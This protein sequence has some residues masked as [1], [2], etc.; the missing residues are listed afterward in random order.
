MSSSVYLLPMSTRSSGW[1][2][3]P[4]RAQTAT[5]VPLAGVEIEAGDLGLRAGRNAVVG[6]RRA[7]A[8]RLD[9]VLHRHAES[10][11]PAQ[12]RPPVRVKDVAAGIVDAVLALLGRLRV[13]LGV[14]A[15]VLST[16]VY[17]YCPVLLEVADHERRELQTLLGGGAVAE[18]HLRL[19]RRAAQR[20]PRRRGDARHAQHV[21]A[22]AAALDA[23]A[24]ARA[25]IETRP[26][27]MSE[28]SF[29]S[30]LFGVKPDG[31]APRDNPLLSLIAA[32]DESQA[33]KQAP[34]H[35]RKCHN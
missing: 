2:P 26:S 21:I 27:F 6:Q 19:H 33:M 5:T 30:G 25:W 4:R 9:D 16:Y 32:R 35:S 7:G 31:L 24:R 34:P 20:R 3:A 15:A 18:P 13:A 1:P 28:R 11:A 12:K 17:T 23:D 8:V 29:P 10:A 22:M 14:I